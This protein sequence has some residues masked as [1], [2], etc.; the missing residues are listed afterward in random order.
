MQEEIDAENTGKPIRL[1][2]INRRDKASGNDGM[3]AGRDLPWLQDTAEADVWE[4]WD[5]EYR[6]VVILG[7]DN[8][9]LDTYNLTQ[10]AL[11]DAANY[12]ALKD[13]LLD[14]AR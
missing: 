10:N 13:K 14:A 6:D 3:V 2:G 12:A 11:D 9:R 4:N 1:V 5:H 7:P 8:R